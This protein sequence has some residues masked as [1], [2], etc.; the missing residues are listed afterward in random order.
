MDAVLRGLVVFLLLLL[1][2]RLS[3][4]RSIAQVTPF[5]FVLLLIISEATQQALLGEDFS[6]TQAAVVILTIIALSRLFDF[7]AFRFGKFQRLTSSV[8]VVIVENGRIVDH[9]AGKSDVSADEIIAAARE[10]QGLER[11]D[12]IKY[13]VLE[14]SGSISIVP[15]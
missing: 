6:V 8:P 14:T 9:A 5:D 4:K 15:R 11:L 7:L 2:F 1:F 12:Q 3:G 10:K 13:A